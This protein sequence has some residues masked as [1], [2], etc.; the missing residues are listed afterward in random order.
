MVRGSFTCRHDHDTI[1]GQKHASRTTTYFP[2]GARDQFRQAGINTDLRGHQPF[3]RTSPGPGP[4]LSARRGLCVAPI[5]C[6]RRRDARPMPRLQAGARA[7]ASEQAAQG[8]STAST[9]T[10][11]ARRHQ[12]MRAASCPWTR[13]ALYGPVRTVRAGARRSSAPYSGAGWPTSNALVRACAAQHAGATCTARA[14]NQPRV[15]PAQRKVL[16]DGPLAQAP[17]DE[18]R[19]SAQRR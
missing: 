18:E 3:N 17:L 4:S 15:E 11:P 5:P 7:R 6:R 9:S 14:Q 13:L 16:V 2:R 10:Q 19:T 8:Y 1:T 12:P